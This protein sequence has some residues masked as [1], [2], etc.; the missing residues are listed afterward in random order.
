MVNREKDAMN[1]V[2]NQKVD[3]SLYEKI[4]TVHSKQTV[5]FHMPWNELLLPYKEKSATKR[6]IDFSFFLLY[7]SRLCLKENII[8]N[9]RQIHIFI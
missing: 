8:N 7:F 2:K 1:Y 6:T 9:L 4:T 3:D 5:K